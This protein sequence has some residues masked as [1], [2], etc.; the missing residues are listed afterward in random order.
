[1]RAW[2]THRHFNRLE[3]AGYTVLEVYANR[4]QRG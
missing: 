1:M 3:A 2:V 4:T